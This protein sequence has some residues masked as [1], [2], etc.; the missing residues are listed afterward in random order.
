MTITSR[1]SAFALPGEDAGGA[2]EPRRARFVNTLSAPVTRVAGP[3]VG[4]AAALEGSAAPERETSRAA[5]AD[6]AGGALG[7]AVSVPERPAGATGFTEPLAPDVGPGAGPRK[8]K[9]EVVDVESVAAPKL[10][11]VAPG[12]ESRK[13]RLRA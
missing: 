8:V 4:D 12:C 10:S 13:L 6:D 3:V 9:G 2:F 11:P 7:A 1:G 5:P